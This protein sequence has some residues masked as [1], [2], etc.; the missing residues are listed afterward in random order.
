[1]PTSLDTISRIIVRAEETGVTEV[2][3]KYH[4]LAAE[5]E[6]A[7][8]V[9]ERGG[10][11]A[12]GAAR[13][14]EVLRKK[15]DEVHR[16][17]RQFE[18]AI[19]QVA[20]AFDQGLI[21]KG[22]EDYAALSR[23]VDKVTGSLRT[24]QKQQAE[25]KRAADEAAAAAEREAEAIAGVTK[26]LD[27][28]IA[29][30]HMGGAEYERFAALQRAGTTAAT[31]GGQA[32][33]SR[34]DT[35]QALRDQERMAASMRE[36]IQRYAP[37]EEA[38]K[39]YD[40]QLKEHD[41]L[42]KA[43]VIDQDRFNAANKAAEA[44]LR[45]SAKG[46]G[47]NSNQLQNLR[48]QL[49]DIISGIGGGQ[50]LG[51]IF[52][53]QAGQIYQAVD[54]PRGISEGFKNAGKWLLSLI[55][56]ATVVGAALAG[57]AYL[58]IKAWNDWDNSQKEVT[59]TL[60]GLGRSLGV[61]KDQFNAMAE[62]AAKAG[63]LS[64][65]SAREMLNTL[66]RTGQIVNPQDLVRAVSLAKDYA[67][68]FTNG[69]I[70]AAMKEQADLIRS[71]AAGIRDQM[72]LRGLIND[73]NRRAIEQAVNLNDTAKAYG[74][75]LDSLNDRLV[76]HEEV[77]GKIATAWD[78]VK[79]AFKDLMDAAGPFLDKAAL[80]LETS[81]R[82][83]ANVLKGD[84]S[85]NPITQ[86]TPN[87]VS[88]IL[89]GSGASLGGQDIGPT[90]MQSQAAR[91]VKESA[92]A[93]NEAAKATDKLKAALEAKAKATRE[94]MENDRASVAPIQDAGKAEADL[95]LKLN[96]RAS[97]L[98]KTLSAFKPGDSVEE[99]K[100]VQSQWTLVTD[101]IKSNDEA[102]KRKALS[103]S[104]SA[105]TQGDVKKA[106]EERTAAEQR[107]RLVQE[108]EIKTGRDAAESYSDQ[109]K[110]LRE[111]IDRKTAISKIPPEKRMPGER[112]D[113]EKITHEIESQSTA[114]GRRITDE[115]KSAAAIRTGEKAIK[116]RTIT[117]RVET[118]EEQKRQELMGKGVTS[119]QARMKLRPLAVGFDSK[120]PTPC[121][122]SRRRWIASRKRSN[123]RKSCCSRPM[124]SARGAPLSWTKRTS[125][126]G[127]M[128]R[129]T[130]R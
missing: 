59:R 58:A 15:T 124:L 83:A 75:F 38:Q 49:N 45:Q 98:S 108:Q 19:R 21:G 4:A 64:V 6:A 57:G 52:V 91:A 74:I 97:A 115:E 93:S 107:Q 56:P 9:L 53:Q 23:E 14:L 130:M 25:A 126:C 100:K 88:A 36:L 81:L 55:T 121:N 2:T 29:R 116:D 113:L 127:P 77:T 46:V 106:L 73:S 123:L 89:S 42:L 22:A 5:G 31:P 102:Q 79:R 78:N 63:D 7:A 66:G 94:S 67:A 80:F 111:L 119:V 118:A 101:A 10:P 37:A 120:P 87:T 110:K 47:L 62:A 85:H 86:A 34:V 28:Q 40:R 95:Q 39:R 12:V 76:K 70:D 8:V 17:T 41:Q 71:G 104:E 33:V 96:D 27:D 26:S 51:T 3:A 65:S 24:V 50:S 61:T 125:S 44:Q 103:D 60:T 84:F 99:M 18:T 129:S 68:T 54:G 48:Y 82:G 35:V 30:L 112:E 92:E 109:D 32:I 128:A 105:A 13:G 72:N 1:M 122:V 11:A 117:Q 114:L 90:E 16:D 20:N 43:G 69:D